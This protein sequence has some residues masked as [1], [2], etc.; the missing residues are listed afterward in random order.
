M[1]CTTSLESTA[2]P[3]LLQLLGRYSDWS[4]LLKSVAWLSKFKIWLRNGKRTLGYKGLTVED[5]DSAKRTIISL[6]QRLSFPDEMRDLK[7]KEPSDC[8]EIEFDCKA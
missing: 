6:V 4:K 3:L 8:E 7:R 2:N 1:T 5:L